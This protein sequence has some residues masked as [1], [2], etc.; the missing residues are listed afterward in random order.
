MAARLLSLL[1][2]A[3]ALASVGGCAD[4][5]PCTQ[6]PPVEGSYVLSFS[7]VQRTTDCATLSPPGGELSV[8]RVGS[9]LHGQLGGTELTGTLYD[10]YDFTL[11]GSSIGDA[12]V[13]D[14]VDL[15]GRYV[16]PSSGADGGDW[17]RGTYSATQ[18]RDERSG[19]RTC[20][21]HASFMGVRR[22]G[23]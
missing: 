19:R 15:V 14:A 20:S 11:A 5:R 2:L 7:D 8:A 10:T 16:P 23:L 13:V 21:V 17:I 4:G 6:C 9:V 12:G 3:P 18:Q 22:E 1:T